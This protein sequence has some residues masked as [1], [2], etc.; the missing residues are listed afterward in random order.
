MLWDIIYIILGAGLVVKGADWLTDGASAVAQRFGI[1]E[2]IIGLTIVAMGTSM[3]EFCVSFVAA[4]KGTPDMAI[5]NIIGSNVFNALMIVGVAAV[6]TPITLTRD[7]VMRDM[8]TAIVA[9]FLLAGMIYFDGKLSRIDSIVLFA[10]FL[11]FMLYTIRKAKQGKDATTTTT[12]RMTIPRALLWIAL[13]LAGLVFGSD[14]F[15]DGASS[16]AAR[17]GVP[18]AVVGLTIAAVGTSLPELATS[19]VAAVKGQS[20]MAIG[21][22][23]GSNVFNVLFILGICGSITP[24]TIAGIGPVDYAMLIGSILLLWLFAFT[25][26]TVQ[27]WEGG[28]LIA[29]Y[30]GYVTYL[31][32][33]V[34]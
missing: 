10:G 5:G 11:G 34:I 33:Q 15:V 28:V 20:A 27:R 17:L 14:I 12:P 26:L 3:P 4:L 8:L 22:V 7:T 24:M 23:I 31:V 21:N 6:F 1:P 9:A 19:T 32:F 18:S 25:R 30:V 2:I 16:V 13:G 29:L